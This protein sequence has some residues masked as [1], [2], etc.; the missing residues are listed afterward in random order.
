MWYYG[1]EKVLNGKKLVATASTGEEKELKLMSP[2]EGQ[3]ML[4]VYLTPNG[5]NS[6]Q[7]QKMKEKAM[8]L[9]DRVRTS[10]LKRHEA[11]IAL[12]NM[13][14]KSLE[15]PLPVTTLTEK[16]CTEIMWQILQKFLPKTGVN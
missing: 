14:M 12:T 10:H 6:L 5:S 3:K 15:Y 11:W 8:M 1:D 9:A 7:F 2:G 13:V 16:E 4:G